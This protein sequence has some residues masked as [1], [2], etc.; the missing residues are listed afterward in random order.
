[1]EDVD[2]IIK[3]IAKI[4]H[5]NLPIRDKQILLQN[6]KKIIIKVGV[7]KQALTWLLQRFWL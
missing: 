6:M 2:L 3:K 5:D 7:R 1:M 4:S